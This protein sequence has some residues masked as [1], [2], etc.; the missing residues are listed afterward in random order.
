MDG[1]EY[2]FLGLLNKAGKISFGE[3]IYSSR[4]RLL[5]LGKQASANSRKRLLDFAAKMRIPVVFEDGGKLG[6]ALGRDF[7]SGVAILDGK[8]AA[9][10]LKKKGKENL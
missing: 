6:S 7:L 8:A 10:Y 9:A 1:K 4:P 5:L 3:A 2:G